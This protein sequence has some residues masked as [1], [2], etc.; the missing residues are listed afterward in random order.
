MGMKISGEEMFRVLQGLKQ[1][2]RM[3][4]AE[5]SDSS[6]N[7]EKV[8]FSSELQQANKSGEVS[9]AMDPERAA[10]L[11]SLKQQISEGSYDPDMKDVASSLLDYLSKMR[12]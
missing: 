12:S 4:Q 9:K 3:R 11:E 10:K 8:D 2:N 5:R 7:S 1:Q 6:S